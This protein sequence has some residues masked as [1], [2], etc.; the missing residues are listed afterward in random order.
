MDVQDF[1]VLS[2]ARRMVYKYYFPGPLADVFICTLYIYVC[3]CP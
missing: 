3:A 1:D 2:T